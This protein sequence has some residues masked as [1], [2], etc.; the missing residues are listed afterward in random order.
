MNQKHLCFDVVAV[1]TCT[2]TN[3]KQ[4]GFTLIEMLVVLLIMGLLVGL[5]SAIA[6]PDDR[7]LLRV[8]AERLAQLM[9]IAATESLLTGKP[10]AWTADETGYRFWKSNED[11][12]WSEIVDDDFLRARTLPK[13]MKISNMRV[14]NTQSPEHM[15]VEFNSYGPAFLF[16]VDMSLGDARYTVASS[17]IGEVRVLPE[18]RKTNDKLVQN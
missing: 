15:R 16:S 6:Q 14:E 5:V 17:P 13:G 11:S 3:V 8:E 2:I 10:I 18:G 7:A 1:K 12:V 4:R 9:D